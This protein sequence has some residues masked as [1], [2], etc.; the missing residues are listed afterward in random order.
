MRLGA[1]KCKLYKG[2][3]ANKAY[4]KLEIMERHRHR[5]EFNNKYREAFKKSG[6]ICSGI[7]PVTDLVEIV[8]IK[9]HPFFVCVQFHPELKSTVERPHPLFVA[10]VKATIKNKFN[11]KA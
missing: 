1:Y 7:N 4:G 3:N 8:E 5:F 11:E 2:S 9:D 10:F 6:M